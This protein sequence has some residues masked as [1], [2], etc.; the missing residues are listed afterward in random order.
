MPL[1]STGS[2]IGTNVKEH[3]LYKLQDWDLRNANAIFTRSV[4]VWPEDDYG[5]LKYVALLIW[6]IITNIHERCVA[7]KQVLPD[8]LA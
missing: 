6:L 4:T 8:F 3:K 2:I 7:G 1:L 5:W